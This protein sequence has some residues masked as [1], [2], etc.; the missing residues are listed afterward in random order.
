MITRDQGK[1]E[2][3]VNALIKKPGLV[4]VSLSVDH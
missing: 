1:P 4:R 3:L 2:V